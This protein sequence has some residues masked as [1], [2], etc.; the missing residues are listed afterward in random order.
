MTVTRRQL[1]AALG[2]TLTDEQWAA[3]SASVDPAVIV[4]GAGSGKTTSMA[5]RVAWLVGSGIARADGVLGLTFTTKATSAL[6][7][8]MRRALAAMAEQGLVETA[9]DDGNPLG[10]PQVLTY[11]AFAARIVGEHGIRLGREPG[12]TM[13]TDGA[14][15]QLAYRVVC[16]TGL[17]L[18]SFGRSPVSIT[19]DLLRLDDELTELGISPDDLRAFDL[20]MLAMLHSFETLQAVGRDM[21]STS[22]QR[23]VLAELVSQWRAEKAARDVLD[24]ADQIRL[25]GEIVGRFGDVV[26]DLCGRYPVV[27]LD[28]YQDTSIAQRVLLQRI[29]GEGHAVMAVGDPCQAIYGWRGASVDNI[30]SFPQ[31]FPVLGVDGAGRRP[32]ARFTLSQNRRSGPQI[33]EVANRTSADLRLVHSGVEPL[34]AGDNGKGSGHVACALFDTSRQEADWLVQ[35]VAA[36]HSAEVPWSAIAVLAATGRDLVVVDTALR[37]SGVPTVSYTH[38]TLPTNREV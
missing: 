8:S 22:T 24:F 35:Q 11:H 18:S 32:A 10:E 37:R 20:E 17:P 38:L 6:L 26:A 4:A 33:L 3:V 9:D 29:F 2:L 27:L 7:T 21:R 12:A 19:S 5:A 23:S 14:R 15:Q 28:E 13:L 25:A 16:R 30:E 1:D 36:T 34:R 31:H